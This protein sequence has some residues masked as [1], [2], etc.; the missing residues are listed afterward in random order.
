MLWVVLGWLEATNF[1]RSHSIFRHWKMF[2]EISTLS[3]GVEKGLR[4]Q[5]WHG[6]SWVETFARRQTAFW[7]YASAG[8]DERWCGGGMNWDPKQLLYKNAITNELWIAASA[9]LFLD[10]PIRDTSGGNEKF[11]GRNRTFLHAAVKGYEWM[12]NSNMTNDKGLFVDGYHVSKLEEGGTVCDERNEAVYTYNQGVILTGQR[13]LWDATGMLRFLTDGHRLIQNTIKATGWDLRQNKA[14]TDMSEHGKLPRWHGIG[15]GGIMEERCDVGGYCSQ[16][17]Q[18]FKGIYFHHL[19]YFCR[20]LVETLRDV[21]QGSWIGVKRA[22]AKACTRYLKWVEHNV[23]AALMTRDSHGVFGQWWGAEKF[24]GPED[25]GFGLEPQQD[26]PGAVDYRND[27]I[28]SDPI[29]TNGSEPYI[30]PGTNLNVPE[31]Q[32]VTDEPSPHGSRSTLF[33]SRAGSSQ[34]RL[35]GDVRADRK[36]AN[37]RG[38]GRTVETQSTGMSLLR[39]WWELTQAYSLPGTV[40]KNS[41]DWVFGGLYWL[42]TKLWF[43]FAFM[44]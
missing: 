2:P 8:W 21:D 43:F 22:H 25:S 11:H 1:I 37:K 26:V 27:G 16:N 17:S 39:C 38:R 31:Q 5:V 34:R 44:H 42:F 35:G 28:P 19:A 4:S 20:P 3:G 32:P 9:K 12:M 18:T 36:D 13:A 29:W 6:N 10:Y 23:E 24:Y 33:R 14:L 30:L 7:G 41:H 40:E 15:R